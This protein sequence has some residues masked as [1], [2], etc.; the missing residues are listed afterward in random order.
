MKDILHEYFHTK[1]YNCIEAD[2]KADEAIER[3]K[4]EK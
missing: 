1:G 3:F 4:S 2:K